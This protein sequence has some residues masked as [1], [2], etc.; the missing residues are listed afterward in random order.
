MTRV[1]FTYCSA[2]P[3]GTGLP[4]R[5]HNSTKKFQI[6]GEAA[7]GGGGE[8]TFRNIWIARNIYLNQNTT[9]VSK[10]NFEYFSSW[11][12]PPSSYRKSMWSKKVPTDFKVTEKGG[13]TPTL[14]NFGGSSSLSSIIAYSMFDLISVDTFIYI[15]CEENDYSI[16]NIV[17]FKAP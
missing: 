12:P 17:K 11:A 8:R 5:E 1:V 6:Y 13:W 16:N 14:A 7:S 15:L 10:P 4:L 2:C 9:Y 3:P